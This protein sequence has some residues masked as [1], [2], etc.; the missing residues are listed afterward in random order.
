MTVRLATKADEPQLMALCHSLHEE[1]G[2][3]NMNEAMVAEML[4]RAFEKRGG[5]IGVIDGPKGIEAGTLLLITTLWYDDRY[6]LEEL[7]VH[8]L[9]EARH[10]SHH[11]DLIEFNK[12]CSDKLGL[13]LVT[14]VLTNSRLEA[15]VRLYQRRLGHPSGAIFVYNAQWSN[16][17]T[18]PAIFAELFKKSEMPV[19]A[20]YIT[21]ETLSR[22]GHGDADKG[23]VM[24][25]KFI[26]NKAP[27]A[28]GMAGQ[29]VAALT[30]ASMTTTPLPML[31]LVA[32]G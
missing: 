28:N 24:I 10:S 31:P 9:P 30:T 27:K 21:H 6:H 7:F 32:N 12:T 4:S 13:A 26:R 19:G 25:E 8:V 29:L 18:N 20:R 3:G 17:K 23:W 15:K 5:I 14:G 11:N 1:N 2:L 16:E 22:L